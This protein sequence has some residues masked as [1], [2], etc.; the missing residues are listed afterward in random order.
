MKESQINTVVDSITLFYGV[1]NIQEVI[2][3]IC[4]ILSTINIAWKLIEKLIES[5]KAKDIQGVKDVVK[6]TVEVANDIAEDLKDD[7]KL[8][9]SNKRGD[10]NG[11]K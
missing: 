6:E 7:G 4:V 2:G 3:L 11:N 1:A 9:G 10:E 5:I 8:N